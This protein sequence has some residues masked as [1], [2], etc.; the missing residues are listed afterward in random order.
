MKKL[1]ISTLTLMIL[2]ACGAGDNASKRANELCDCM[3]KDGLK[4]GITMQEAESLGD[5]VQDNS[6]AY[7]AIAGGISSD[8]KE[9]DKNGKKAY[10]K[11]LLKAMIDTECMDFALDAVPFDM[12]GLVAGPQDGATST[13]P[14][15]PETK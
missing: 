13:T 9:L 6:I 3:K 12:L 8:M 10:T 7:L 15:S 11:A 2:S 1:F 5:K 4:K 14:D